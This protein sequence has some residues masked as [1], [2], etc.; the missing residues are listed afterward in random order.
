MSD[1]AILTVTRTHVPAFVELPAN[2]TAFT[3]E[4]ARFEAKVS[5]YPPPALQWFLNRTSLPNE[6]NLIVII[7]ECS[8]ELSGSVLKVVATN[9][10]GTTN[11]WALTVIPRPDL[12]FTEVMPRQTDTRPHKDWF[13]VS[14]S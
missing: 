5:G 9:P 10:L 3:R 8:L 12:R 13:E 7:E 11:A 2:R 14:N 1:P 4:R 6:T